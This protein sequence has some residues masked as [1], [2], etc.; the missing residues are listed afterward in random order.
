[1]RIAWQQPREQQPVGYLFS[2]IFIHS[3]ALLFLSHV[4]V[5]GA[6]VTG[7]IPVVGI[8]IPF[9]SYGGSIMFSFCFAFGIIQALWIHRET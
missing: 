7:M 6:M 4:L 3:V 5:N 1:M 2:L 8:P 9:V